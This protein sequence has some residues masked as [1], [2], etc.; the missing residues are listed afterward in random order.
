LWIVAAIIVWA[1]IDLYAPR[2]GNLR[3]FDPS[4][5][6]RLETRMWQSYYDRDRLRLFGQLAELLR[7]QYHL[8]FLRSHQV[9]YQAAKAAF[10]F[11]DGRNREDYQKALPNL[12]KYYAA[13]LNV[14]LESFNVDRVA[15][16]ELE[17]WIVHRERSSHSLGDLERALAEVPAE[18]YR[19]PIEQIREHT[20]LRAEA[21][22][23]RDKRAETG[24]VTAE[25]WARINH[26]LAASWQSLWKV[27]NPHF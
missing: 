7:T 14:S 9:G 6:A 19:L 27:L 4:E 15:R 11:K 23:L 1:A 2:S 26:L 22:L 5:V 8:P 20:R 24:S 25:D 21:M 13:I 18:V 17:W 12:V 3:D 10:V 16:K